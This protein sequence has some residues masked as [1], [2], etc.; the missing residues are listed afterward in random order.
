MKIKKPSFWDY[1][2]PNFL[3]Y[4]LLPFTIII[5]INNLLIS[6]RKNNKKNNN[7]KCICLGNIYIGGT[8]KTPLSIKIS[9]VL[10]KLNYKT[11][12]IKKFYKDQIDEQKLLSIKNKLYC[13]RAR[14]SS[15]NQAIKDNMS[16]AIFDDGLQDYS[17]NYDLSFVCF[18]SLKWIGNGQLIPAG[19]LREKIKSLLKYDAV[20]LT[21]NGEDNEDLKLA[22]KEVSLD[23]K[24]FEA[25]YEANNLEKFNKND[26]F[27][28]FSGIGNPESFKATLIKNKFNIIKEL[29]FPDHYH[30]TKNDIM[31]IKSHAKE[32]NAKILTT[33]K[34]FVKINNNISD[35]IDFLEINLIIKNENNL[36]NFI[37]S[38]I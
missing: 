34:D 22:I 20:F 19:P 33:E 26:K 11:A 37:N 29:N 17:I 3:S 23:I 1:K 8:A 16:I 24:I 12:I 15:L 6:F 38:K 18:N 35:G 9:D 28:I 32:S 21:G 14:V 5:I 7:I 2:R 25:S 13:S 10:N 36:I 31:K 30:Y 27:I 4:I